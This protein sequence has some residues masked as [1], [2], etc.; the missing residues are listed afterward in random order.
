M[1][2]MASITIRPLESNV[3][4]CAC[5]EVQNKACNSN[6]ILCDLKM[7]RII[8]SNVV[9]PMMSYKSYMR[10]QIC[11]IFPFGWIMDFAVL[12]LIINRSLSQSVFCRLLDLTS[13][14][15]GFRDLHT[16]TPSPLF[17]YSQL[18]GWWDYSALWKNMLNF[19]GM[20]TT[21][22]SLINHKFMQNN[23]Y[24]IKLNYWS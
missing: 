24:S 14:C 18:M 23:I 8:L 1:L 9:G 2:S 16:H 5:Y 12:Q 7:A 10:L 19:D 11:S 20:K 22:C 15:S 3:K 6:I 21:D 13:N 4:K 17:P